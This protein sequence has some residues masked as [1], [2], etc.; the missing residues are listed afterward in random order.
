VL[1][2][3]FFLSAVLV[4]AQPN[5][6]YIDYHKHIILAEQQFLYYNTP[7]GAI[8]KYKEIFS[9]W[10]KP[11]AKDC[12]VALQLACMMRD[13]A[14][15]TF[16]KEKSFENGVEWN[17]VLVS[18]H[19]QQLFF[20]REYKEKMSRVYEIK[21]REYLETIDTGY[22][23][24]I[25]NMYARE[26]F[27]RK[28]AKGN[29][30]MISEWMRVE[31]SNMYELVTMI[32]KTGFPGEKRIGLNIGI[33]LQVEDGKTGDRK[34]G[35]DFAMTGIFLSCHAATLFFHHR[36]GYQLL[37]DELMQAVVEGELHPRE[38][39]LM[40]E[41]S[42]AYFSRK[43]WDDKYH[44]FKC[45]AGKWEKRYNQYIQSA[46]HYSDIILVNKHRAELG[47]CS[48]EHDAKKKQYAIENKLYLYFG[49]FQQ[50]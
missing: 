31:D 37:K 39:A 50:V 13:T 16:F 22:R 15:A 28:Q 35:Y 17:T 36:C 2:L 46:Y 25:H 42:H 5:T 9:K 8:N 43:N 14:N 32:K 11:F 30:Y 34:H 18:E 4:I 44:D 41:W 38:Y 33:Y 6:N 23:N 10:D 27:F 40:Y 29:E 48:V 19:V 47:I 49:M 45:T 12:F 3:S 7:S 26:I 21:N 1:L 20:N 24:I